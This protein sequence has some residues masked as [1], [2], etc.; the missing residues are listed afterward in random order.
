M[1]R[2]FRS[3]PPRKNKTGGK[4]SPGKMKKGHLRRKENTKQ[5]ILE[6]VIELGE[7]TRARLDVRSEGGVASNVTLMRR[8]PE[9]VKKNYLVRF[10]RGKA[11]VYKPTVRA[12]L[13]VFGVDKLLKKQGLAKQEVRQLVEVLDDLEKSD[14]RNAQPW[15]E[16]IKRKLKQEGVRDI[17]RL[18]SE[19]KMDAAKEN[20][21]KRVKKAEAAQGRMPFSKLT[22]KIYGVVYGD[23]GGTIASI[24]KAVG[25]SSKRVEAEL[26]ALEE[27]G[28]I[29]SL[30]IGGMKI[31]RP[32]KGVLVSGKRRGE[33]RAEG[34]PKFF[35]ARA[36][37]EFEERKRAAEE[38]R[39][40]RRQFLPQA[41]IETRVAKI[42]EIKETRR[43]IGF[44]MERL[45][46]QQ[47]FPANTAE[48]LQETYNFL[49]RNSKNQKRVS[50]LEKVIERLAHTKHPSKADILVIRSASAEMGV[51]ANRII[52]SLVKAGV[53][54][55]KWER[56]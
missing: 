36:R 14:Y 52:S 48:I 32:P 47:P 53:S 40:A 4:N 16:R 21:T 45:S 3:K 30:R 10:K 23:G 12:K 33:S 38:S 18:V 26:R 8:L 7:A 56:E 24:A 46:P 54:P 43:D 13:R 50:A 31:Y 44:L 5:R 49:A 34:V 2:V 39:K 28:K 17:R 51:I 19:A 22:R 1:K 37:A 35:G 15:I 27:T 25:E 41:E 9:L 6:R 42:Q 11:F 55:G 20:V 29:R